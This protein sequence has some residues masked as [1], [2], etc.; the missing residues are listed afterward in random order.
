MP[1]RSLPLVTALA[2]LAVA[3]F[4]DPLPEFP[5]TTTTTS[6]EPTGGSTLATTT[7]P[8]FCGDGEVQPGEECDKGLAGNG[9]C[10][11]ECTLNVCG[12]GYVGQGESC[13]DLTPECVAC[14]LVSCGDGQL[15]P[16]EQCDDSN[17]DD[18]DACPGTCVP[19]TCGDGFVR[20]GFEQ[21][22]DANSDDSDACVAGCVAASCGDGLL[23][24]G[25]EGCDDGNNI[26]GDGCSANCVPPGCGDNV[27][28]PGEACDDGNVASDDGCSATCQVESCGDGIKQASEACDDGNLDDSDACFI[29][30]TANVCGDGILNVLGEECDHGPL[31]NDD[32]AKGACTATC[33]RAAFLVFVTS[34]RLLPKLDFAGIDGADMYC[35]ALAADDLGLKIKGSTWKAWIGVLDASPAATFFPS[36]LPYVQIRDQAATTIAL[37]YPD[38]VDGQ[39]LASIRVTDLGELLNTGNECDTTNLVWTGVYSDGSGS[40]NHCL[41][42][43]SNSTNYSGTAGSVLKGDTHWSDAKCGLVARCNLAARFYCFEQPHP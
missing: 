14:K 31:N 19:A 9:A 8:G 30:C 13:D 17:S 41:G 10:T 33:T 27:Q 20:T 42:W 29:D 4:V 21:C 6:G 38:L 37:N 32:P 12:D 11:N 3:C 35:A 18:S 43:L 15:D 26:D 25:V 39:L 16:G 22:D 5:G 1:P 23:Q 40:N 36:T 2:L 28:Q 34:K 24:V 7:Y